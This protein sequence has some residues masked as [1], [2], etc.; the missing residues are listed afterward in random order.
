VILLTSAYA[1]TKP[2]GSTKCAQF[3]PLSLSWL[4]WLSRSRRSHTQAT[5]TFLRRT[6]IKGPTASRFPAPVSLN[7]RVWI[8]GL[9]APS[10]WPMGLAM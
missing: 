7:W 4:P 5:C 10:H 6:V 1:L 9:P 8:N 3:L 2:R